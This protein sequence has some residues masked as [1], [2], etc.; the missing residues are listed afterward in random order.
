MLAR[1]STSEQSSSRRR[2]IRREMARVRRRIDH[3]V[4]RYVDRTQCAGRLW[5]EC[6]SQRTIGPLVVGVAIVA[7]ACCRCNPLKWN[8]SLSD[9]WGRFQRGGAEGGDEVTH[10]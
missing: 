2:S 9:L 6:R 8:E 7:W 1:Q 10:E 4:V 3:R 5:K